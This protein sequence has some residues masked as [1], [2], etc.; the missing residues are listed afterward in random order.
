MHLERPKSDFGEK[1]RSEKLA[2]VIARSYLAQILFAAPYK[3]WL[4]PKAKQI[5]DD[6]GARRSRWWLAVS[7][8]A[9]PLPKRHVA[10]PGDHF[11]RTSPTVVLDSPVR[12]LLL[13]HNDCEVRCS[14]LLYPKIAH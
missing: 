3:K 9:V 13:V 14:D 6:S 7:P 11:Y 8:Q 12:V 10:E 1:I 2:V 5:Y 4:L